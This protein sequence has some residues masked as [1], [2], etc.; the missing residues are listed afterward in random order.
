MSR[1]ALSMTSERSVVVRVLEGHGDRADTAALAEWI[2]ANLIDGVRSVLP[3]SSGVLIEFDVLHRPGTQQ[4]GRVAELIE[5]YEHELPGCLQQ[6]VMPRTRIIP[7]CY[8]ERHAPDLVR[9][10]ETLGIGRDEIVDRH[11]SGR[12]MVETVGFMPGFGYL[13]G[14]DD[15]LRL[16]RLDSP[17]TR[18]PAGSVAIAE[19]L[20]GVYPHQSAGG[21]HLIGRTPK[22]LFDPKKTEPSIL[23][24][25]DTVR[26]VPI[27][28][29]EFEHWGAPAA[30]GKNG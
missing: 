28:G 24:V 14:L 23:R 13:S 25:G 30:G 9:A 26:F 2:E 17:R 1:W 16:P 8:D 22:A 12:Y 15:S 18:V 4:L 29:S 5:L 3:A 20:T 21:W 27:S 7:V 19:S 11:A 6:R 10:A